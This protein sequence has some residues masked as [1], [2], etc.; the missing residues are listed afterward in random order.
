MKG[1]TGMAGSGEAGT[2]SEAAL[3]A[4]LGEAEPSEGE[5]RLGGRLAR[6][7]AL[8]VAGMLAAATEGGGNGATLQS[9]LDQAITAGAQ[10]L[11]VLHHLNTYS[12]SFYSITN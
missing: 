7:E 2:P 10:I 1:E 8:N 12:H 11:S 6:L 5:R 9:R 4:L 3:S